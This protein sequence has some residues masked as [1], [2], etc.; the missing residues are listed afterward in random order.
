MDVLV[1][2]AT[3]K[4]G[5]AI[6]RRLVERGDRVR[7]LVRRPAEAAAILPDGVESVA[8]DVT[9]PASIGDAVAGC[10]L[11]FNAMGLPEHWVR[12]PF[13]FDRVNAQGTAT[14]VRAAR[15]AGARRL[16]H[17]S[18]IDVFHARPGGPLDEGNLADYPKPSA[19]ERSKQKAEELA[20]GERGELEVVIVNAAAVYGP[21][22]ARDTSL[23]HTFMAPLV[24]K[25][26]PL[27]PPGGMGVVFAD[28]LALGQ[29]SAAAHGRDGERY[30]LCDCHVSFRELAE[31][32]VRVAG[33]GRVPPTM[34]VALAKVMAAGG[35][36]IA[37]IVRRPP[38]L[39]RGQ[40]QFMLWDAVPSSTKAERELDWQP[41]PLEQ[42]VASSLEAL[43]LLGGS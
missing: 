7:A 12:D 28:G 17:T 5:H 37:R 11:V 4:V 24:R 10:E 27:L 39:T 42:G 1:L 18:T 36:A 21:G 35:D 31:T 16:V 30:I 9:A 26:L 38:P 19:Y 41:T 13:V 3:G 43:G 20:L 15:A 23:D 8:G 25:R 33:R 40:L 22:P 14:V 32:V 2:G 6:A 29:L 34:P